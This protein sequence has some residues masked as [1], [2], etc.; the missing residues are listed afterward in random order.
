MSL[1]GSEC[2]NSASLTVAQ[3]Q[4]K[5]STLHDYLSTPY[6]A[7]AEAILQQRRRREVR[8]LLE[9]LNS[10]PTPT[11]GASRRTTTLEQASVTLDSSRY[12]PNLSRPPKHEVSPGEGH[13]ES[14]APIAAV[15]SAIP[16]QLKS[17][18]SSHHETSKVKCGVGG[19]TKPPPRESGN[20]NRYVQQL[21]W[22][23]RMLADA[24]G[25]ERKRLA[26]IHLDVVQPLLQLGEA[27]LQ[28]QTQLEHEL[29]SCRSRERDDK[30]LRHRKV[31]GEENANTLG[32][33]SRNGHEGASGNATCP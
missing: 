29:A 24:L 9:G 22:Q 18:C 8:A 3:L 12:A 11:E 13:E 2:G 28:R 7:R 33:N 31:D 32:N 26:E 30:G 5:L 15:T 27:A 23:V 20:T 6:R 14:P 10:V 4:E 17:R 25:Q 16:T 1:G 19:L 21:E